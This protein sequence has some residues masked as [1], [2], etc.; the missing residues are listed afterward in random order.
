MSVINYDF[1]CILENKYK[2][3]NLLDFIKNRSDRMGLERI[4][5]LLCHYEY[6]ELINDP[7]LFYIA[8]TAD[9]ADTFVYNDYLD[10]CE[11]Y[12]K[13]PIKVYTGR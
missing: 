13:I 4:F 6:P 7:S 12:K 1:L 10:Y 11:K 9:T 5:G 3:F 8:N 2:F